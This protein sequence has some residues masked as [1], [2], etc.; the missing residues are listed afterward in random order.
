MARVRPEVA[1]GHFLASVEG[2]VAVVEGEV[3]RLL[4]GIL[5]VTQ[6]GRVPLHVHNQLR[7]PTFLTAIVEV[8]G[9]GQILNFRYR[10]DIKYIFVHFLIYFC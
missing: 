2:P 3:A 4:P 7:I 5:G 8:R 10:N 1:V 9:Q 6:V